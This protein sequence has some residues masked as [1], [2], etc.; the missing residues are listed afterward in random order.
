MCHKTSHYEGTTPHNRRINV[1]CHF[2]IEVS[3][4]N[5]RNLYADILKD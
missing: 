4:L 1:L 2:A 5:L 3:F